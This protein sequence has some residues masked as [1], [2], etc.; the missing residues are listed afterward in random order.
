MRA[1]SDRP[2]CQRRQHKLLLAPR[3]QVSRASTS[4]TAS[5]TPFCG[6]TARLA[7]TGPAYARAR[8]RRRRGHSASKRPDGTGTIWLEVCGSIDEL[9][10]GV[11]QLRMLEPAR[12]R[13][14]RIE[15]HIIVR[16]CTGRSC[17]Q[18]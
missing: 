18:V 17:E 9:E 12:V 5:D 11:L 13:A 1:A 8:R 15:P 10:P 3:W 16:M 14:H 7:S 4:S 6:V 2:E